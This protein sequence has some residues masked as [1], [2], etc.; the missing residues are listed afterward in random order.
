MR[1]LPNF[2]LVQGKIYCICK[3][4]YDENK[5]YL[6]CD[7]CDEQ[8]DPVWFHGSCVGVTYEDSLKM[9]RYECFECQAFLKADLENFKQ[10]ELSKLKQ[11]EE[12]DLCICN[13]PFK[14]SKGSIVCDKCEKSFHFRCIGI[15]AKEADMMP[16]YICPFCDPL[17][18]LNRR[19]LLKLKT[20]TSQQTRNR[21]KD[22][23]KQA[24][25][26]FRAPTR[27]PSKTIKRTPKSPEYSTAAAGQSETEQ[28]LFMSRIHR[29]PSGSDSDSSLDSQG[30][31]LVHKRP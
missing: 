1:K 19:A 26:T 6:R 30:E 21:E 14:Y 28:D 27:R 13:Q 10:E 7:L 3:T 11:K 31:E 18:E 5:F 20:E 16:G 17:T 4:V 24:K 25:T 22:V 2:N 15:S 12:K 23:G 8:S 29:R 9:Y